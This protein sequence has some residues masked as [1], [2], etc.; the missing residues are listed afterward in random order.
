[1]AVQ[2]KE[3]GHE[4]DTATRDTTLWPSPL[5]GPAWLC[6]A[7]LPISVIST[8]HHGEFLIQDPDCVG[9]LCAIRSD[10][11][12]PDSIYYFGPIGLQIGLESTYLYQRH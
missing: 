3:G 7:D 4:F 10:S 9:L 8:L 2:T 12:Y 6:L 1:M 5:A 11:A